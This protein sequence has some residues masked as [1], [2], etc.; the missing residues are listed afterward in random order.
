V[1]VGVSGEGSA[2][3]TVVYIKD[4]RT[5]AGRNVAVVDF[6]ITAGVLDGPCVPVVCSTGIVATNLG[7]VAGYCVYYSTL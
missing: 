3:Q 6:A 4:G 1:F 7:T 2:A 5:T